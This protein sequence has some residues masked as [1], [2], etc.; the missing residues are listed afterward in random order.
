MMHKCRSIVATQHGFSQVNYH[1]IG[2]N[3][4]TPIKSG[5][6]ARIPPAPRRMAARR[7]DDSRR[8]KPLYS[9]VG[10][11]GE[12]GKFAM[13]GAKSIHF[14]PYMPYM[15]PQWRK[16]S[17]PTRLFAE[18]RV[19]DHPA[20]PD[21][22]HT[23]A[24]ERDP[25]A[26][27]SDRLLHSAQDTLRDGAPRQPRETPPHTLSEFLAIYREWIT[28]ER[29]EL[30]T[31]QEQ[32][33][34][35]QMLVHCMANTATIA[36]AIAQL[37]HFAP[38]VWKD[39]A[40]GGLREESDGC[41]LLFCDQHRPGPSGLIA[42]IWLLSLTLRTLEFLSNT[43][44]SGTSGRVVHDACLPDGVDRLLFDAPITYGRDEV[45]LIIPHPYL[46]R[47]V[48]ARPADLQ[49]FF[50]QILPLTLGAAQTAPAMGTM[51]SG[52]IR[53]QVQGQS[54]HVIRRDR[55]AAMLGLSE[56]T[57]RRRLASEGMTFRDVRDQTF[58]ALAMD[59]LESGDVSISTIAERLGFSDAFAF[60]RFFRRR[61]AD[62]PSAF[63]KAWAQGD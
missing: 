30:G 19:T 20:L 63:R 31:Q 43:R 51:V 1:A 3:G 16:S 22:I 39:R 36:E 42:S 59:W 60:R 41:A 33:A 7:F 5:K 26:E 27:A 50:R 53:D 18:N 46:R 9:R 62:P 4:N 34:Q 6:F 23:K 10:A 13:N 14:A 45:A 52:L 12:R 47:P 21:T 55:L 35:W 29:G 49:L 32:A 2:F 28:L 44:F 61:H 24:Q 25:L 56:A 40:P 57:M 8:T 38:V 48:V 58:D 11:C 15:A 37:L 54:D 17:Y